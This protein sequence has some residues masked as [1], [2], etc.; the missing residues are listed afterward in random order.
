M[1]K[2]LHPHPDKRWSSEELVEFMRGVCADSIDISLSPIIAE[3]N[4][5][6]AKKPTFKEEF[7]LPIIEERINS[8]TKYS[9]GEKNYTD[10]YHVKLIEFMNQYPSLY[11]MSIVIESRY[12]AKKGLNRVI[13][14]TNTLNISLACSL[15]ASVLLDYTDAMKEIKKLNPKEIYVFEVANELDGGLI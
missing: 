6:L 9:V 4:P 12:Y 1:I 3:Y 5:S 14:Q 15:I 11:L 2:C 8:I 7:F 10:Q 13:G